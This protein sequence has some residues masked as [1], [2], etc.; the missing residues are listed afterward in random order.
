MCALEDKGDL[1]THFKTYQILII[2]VFLIIIIYY[3]SGTLLGLGWGFF[4]GSILTILVS[5]FLIFLVFSLFLFGIRSI[6]L[7]R[8]KFNFKKMDVFI[9]I[10][11][12]VIL[13]IL[14]FYFI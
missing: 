5:I 6:K 10:F 4:G 11:A 8:Q 14:I 13:A 9:I 3:V 2:C 1:T 12:L 7:G